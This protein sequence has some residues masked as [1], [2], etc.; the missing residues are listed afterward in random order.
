MKFRTRITI[1][2]AVLSLLMISVELLIS[3]LGVTRNDQQIAV[4]SLLSNSQQV[5]RS[6]DM[7]LGEASRDMEIIA[8]SAFL[9]EPGRSKLSINQR[10]ADFCS[11]SAPLAR[12]CF[13]DTTGVVAADSGALEVGQ[14]H[15]GEAWQ[16]GMA[17]KSGFLIQGTQAQTLQELIFYAPVRRDVATAPKGVVIASVP[18]NRVRQLIEGFQ[19]YR[20]RVDLMDHTGRLLYTSAGSDGLNEVKAGQIMD[21]P[22][23]TIRYK[24]HESDTALHI[25]T[26]AEGLSI[27]SNGQWYLRVTVPKSQ[28]FAEARSRLYQKAL[29]NT[30]MF[31]AG[32][33]IIYLLAG[34][35]SKPLESLA[36]AVRRRG[37]GDD[38]PLQRLPERTDEFA[39]LQENLQ[40]MSD[41]LYESMERLTISEERFHALF[42]AM[43]EGASLHRML[44]DA[45]GAPED[46]LIDEVNQSYQQILGL[47]RD[48]VLGKTAARAYQTAYPPYL[49]EYATVVATGQPCR[50]ETYFA[51]LERH[52]S[53]SACRV[54]PERF[55]TIFEDITARKWHE[56]ALRNTM[57]QLKLAN[58]AKS[59]FLA[60]MSHEIRTPLNGITGMVQL[61]RDMELPPSQREYL[62]FIDSSADSLLTVINDILDF[63]KI[64]AGK[65]ELELVPFAPLKMLDD[66]LRVMRL[67]AQ[68][69]GLMLSLDYAPD[70][71]EVLVGD[72][73]RLTQVL[74][75]LVGNAIKFTAGGEI[76]VRAS[77][78]L[79][80]D[81]IVQFTVEVQDPGI[82]MDDATQQAIFQPFIQADSSTTRKYGGTGLGLAIC[83]QLVTLMHGSI[84]VTSRPGYGSSFKF[85]VPM[86]LGELPD[87]VTAPDV[88]VSASTSL[89]RPLRVLVAE[90]QP[91]N[92]RFVAEILRKKGHLPLLANN[93]REAVDIWS[94][95]PLDLV[96]MDI[97]MPVLDGLKALAAIRAAEDGAKRHTPIIALTAHAIVGDQERLLNAG[98]DG[99]LSKPLQV[100]NLFEE[101]ARVLE[102]IL[103]ERHV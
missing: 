7:L 22:D 86:T 88:A 43:A 59:H 50:F 61:L 73:H 101:M 46:Y 70:Q 64:E 60:V 37:V 48:Q 19:S 80:D 75:N 26:L 85:S 11:G 55:A 10:L 89:D 1:T 93:G 62:N 79:Q 99:Y 31:A 24:V 33:V 20:V 68:A 44:Y 21:H 35:F 15:K 38:G 32:I 6:V 69:K 100:A 9:N 53:I 30:V 90:D 4:H 13:L 40:E 97:Q 82:G 29:I 71:P 67:R 91:V 96:L 39:V 57:E 94:K 65:L 27:G 18:V 3:Y 102:Q 63:S 74:N 84:N 5:A 58:E 66:T 76:V 87:E 34:R 72:P 51:P 98:F 41:R 16:K 92:Q 47:A 78:E 49:E 23:R 14:P 45:D 81:S 17:G 12:L 42:D 56:D 8:R 83:K 2:F 25:M 36:H 95:E 77:A 103:K 54:G 28:I 52:F